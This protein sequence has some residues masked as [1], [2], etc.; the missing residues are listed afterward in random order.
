MKIRSVHAGHAP[1]GKVGA[2]EPIGTRSISLPLEMELLDSFEG[3]FH[4]D[5]EEL[6]RHHHYEIVWIIRGKGTCSID[7]EKHMISNNCVFCLSPGT[8]H[9]FEFNGNVHGFAISF[10]REFVDNGNAGGEVFFDSAFRRFRNSCMI[11]TAPNMHA[12][13][14]AV[15]DN[16]RYELHNLSPMHNYV[17]EGY[18]R[19]FLV[20]LTRH[21]ETL[22]P[23]TILFAPLNLTK[24]FLALLDRYYTIYHKVSEYADKLAVTPSHLNKLVKMD[25]G[26]TIRE[27]IQQRIVLEAKRMALSENHSLKEVAYSLGFEDLSHFSKFF[28]TVSG[29]NYTRFK[30]TMRL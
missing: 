10:K 9:R 26:L 14:I 3:N 18:L 11:R 17:L 6:H 30:K 8:V 27:H 20:Y 1:M 4:T 16:M 19:I 23:V 28:K 7:F 12:G 24:K 5:N 25:S 13:M 2:H 15:M 22:R 21:Q 29:M